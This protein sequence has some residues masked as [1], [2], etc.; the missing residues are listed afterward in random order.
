MTPPPPPLDEDL[1]RLS[2]L[3]RDGGAIAP[4]LLRVQADLFAASRRRADEAAAFAE[5]A[6]R[7]LP[8]ADA[9]TATHVARRVAALPQT[10][11][12][13]L[14][15]LAA[16]GGEAARLVAALAPDAPGAADTVE[17]PVAALARARRGDLSLDEIARLV[18]RDDPAVDLALAENAD[19]ALGGR[20]LATLVERA[21]GD[22][23][24]LRTR[25]AG[26]LLAR[27]D[28]PADDA[29]S[30]YAQADEPMRTR[31]LVGI[32]AAPR[33]DAH[34]SVRPRPSA[35]T[36]ATLLA[37]AERGDRATFGS[38]LAA[39]LA[40]ETS[41]DWRFH[42]PA[43]HDLLA[44]ALRAAGLG[45]EETIR[46]FLTLDPGIARSVTIVYRLVGLIR[47]VPRSVAARIVEAVHGVRIG[48]QRGVGTTHI[49]ML[50][51]DSR[52]RPRFSRVLEPNADKRD[53]K[54]GRAV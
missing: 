48:A 54:N 49:P 3:A 4:V 51:A 7:L 40:L 38:A 14:Q 11:A 33:A 41:P 44:L 19:A 13:V 35:E 28:L 20:S 39:A 25:L 53:S 46:I 10:P 8:R 50:G 17:P 27:D 21:R 42:E 37:A 2:A 29:A 9:D 1:A 47:G 24:P 22:R 52:H 31:L 5:L 30:L 12:A 6:V 45:E 36:V 32:T 43:R 26:A 34:P 15:A 23:I 16:H 18:A